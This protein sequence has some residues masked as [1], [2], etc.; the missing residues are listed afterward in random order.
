M[1]RSKETDEEKKGGREGVKDERE[2]KEGREKQHK[3]G[4]RWAF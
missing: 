1:W 2:E 4:C 3:I